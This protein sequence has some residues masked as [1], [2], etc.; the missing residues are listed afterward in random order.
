MNEMLPAIDHCESVIN[1]DTRLA[2]SFTSIQNSC[3]FFSEEINKLVDVNTDKKKVLCAVSGGADSMALIVMAANLAHKMQWEITCVTVDHQLRPESLEEAIF[4][5]QFCAERNI[6]HDILTWDRKSNHVPLNKIEIM[7]RDARYALMCDFCHRENIDTVLTGHNWN[8][9]LETFEMRELAG[10][11]LRGLAGMS[12]SRLL[13]INVRLLRPLLHFSKVHLRDFLV[14]KKI[15]W[16]EDPM[17]YREEFKRVAIRK[18]IMSYKHDRIM[19]ISRKI[20]ELGK[21]R[22]LIE[23]D[24]VRFLNN[25][26]AYAFSNNGSAIIN[27]K[28]FGNNSIEV[29]SEILRRI[30]WYI[31]GKKYSTNMPEITL[32]KIMS[33]EINTIGRCLIG[34]KKNMMSIVRENRNGLLCSNRHHKISGENCNYSSDK[35][36]LFDV[37]I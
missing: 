3:N 2:L 14:A 31:G 24:A 35:I 5:K 36:N 29:Q 9:Q 16:K 6:K 11:S 34:I 4:V 22:H 10:S 1:C 7:A 30:I 33:R 19:N 32:N 13:S 18:R 28:K 37:F 20:M 12:M 26:D 15:L 27:L 23:V 17:N 8:D 25:P 21:S